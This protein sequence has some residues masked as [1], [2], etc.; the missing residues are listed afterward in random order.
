MPLR[1]PLT[2]S[3][4]GQPAAIGRHA[5]VDREGVESPN[6]KVVRLPPD[7]L[8]QQPGIDT[9]S[10]HRRRRLRWPRTPEGGVPRTWRGR[11][12][13]VVRSRRVAHRAA[14]ACSLVQVSWRSARPK[15]LARSDRSFL[16]TPFLW[17][18]PTGSS[19][20]IAKNPRPGLRL[21]GC[22]GAQM[23]TAPSR[24]LVL[25]RSELR[26]ERAS[27]SNVDVIALHDRGCQRFL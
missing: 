12:R 10:D 3:R 20:G 2:H 16:T 19:R 21:W 7:D 6:P 27:H 11:L 23:A 17:D 24:S 8:V 4:D 15:G 5:Y 1:E 13:R 18:G 25:Q 9:G 26:A 14:L 22:L